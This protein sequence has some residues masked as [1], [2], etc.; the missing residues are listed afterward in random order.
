[1][2]SKRLALVLVLV[3]ALSSLIMV[4][5][6]LA[7]AQT[8]TPMPIVTPSSSPASM[9]TPTPTVPA[10]TPTPTPTYPKPSIPEF[11]VKLVS[12]TPETNETRI[13]LTITNQPFDRNNT[14]HYSF[15]YN[16]RTRINDGN[17]SDVYTPEDGYPTQS[18]SDYTVLS[19]SSTGNGDEYFIDTNSQYNGIHAPSNAKLDLQVEAMIGYRKRSWE[20]IGGQMLPYVFEGETSGWSNTQTLTISDSPTPTPTSQ[21][22]SENPSLFS[23]SL[24]QI[25]IIVLS[26][27]VAVLL[28]VVV[29]FLRRRSLNPVV[30]S[31]NELQ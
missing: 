8:T 18:D 21:S 28:V 31:T 25:A 13:E 2:M 15:F 16:V 20:F 22:G 6:E 29:V 26:V 23:F 11:T 3:L 1:M 27:M 19:F 4:E 30:Q 9:P 7:S 17:W 5:P 14:D 24:E 10:S 12:L